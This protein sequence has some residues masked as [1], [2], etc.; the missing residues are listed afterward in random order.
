MATTATMPQLPALFLA[1]ATSSSQVFKAQKQMNKLLLRP[2]R[3]LRQP[4]WLKL[5]ILRTL[6]AAFRV[7]GCTN[8]LSFY[9]QFT[10]KRELSLC[11]HDL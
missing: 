4:K 3:L 6:F 1:K 8:S 9:W 5:P 2:L 7:N 11:L 10:Q